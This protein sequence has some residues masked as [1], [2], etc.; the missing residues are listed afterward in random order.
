M[1]LISDQLDRQNDSAES[2]RREFGK[3]V[4]ILAEERAIL[5]A[6]TRMKQRGRDL[7]EEETRLVRDK[8]VAL[9]A[10]VDIAARDNFQR[11]SLIAIER[12]ID[13]QRIEAETLGMSAGQSAAYRAEVQALARAK[14]QNITVTQAF[15][16]QLHQEA[17]A[18]GAAVEATARMRESFQMLRD[19]GQIAMR[20]LEGVFDSFLE[21]RKISWRDAM[22]S[23]ANDLAKLMLRATV[24]QPLLGGG[25]SG[26]GLLGSLFSGIMG[27]GGGVG[28][29][30]TTTTS[31]LAGGGPVSSG[32]PYLV[33]EEGPELFQPQ[34]SGRIV[35]NGQFGGGGGSVINMGG[36]S[37][38]ARGATPDAVRALEARLPGLIMT[39]LG[40]ARERGVRL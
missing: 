9:G 38:D 29:W 39:T 13:A 32:K 12:Q 31:A 34:S 27:P 25:N 23:M 40:E 4:G 1:K 36:L 26:S 3:S 18:A 11:Q 8:A 7:T 30:S 5:E 37:I 33:G 19:T 2:R 6:S 35:P 28:S 14:E 15:R 10:R 24:L 16:D 22:A 21:G 20:G 17:A